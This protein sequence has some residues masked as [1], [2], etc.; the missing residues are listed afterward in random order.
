MKKVSMFFENAKPFSQLVGLFFLLLVGMI[1][2]GGVQA[3][4]PIEGEGAGQ[5]RMMLVVQAVSQL[6]MFL[7]PV[8]IFAG[9]F[10]PGI[11][12]YLKLKGKGSWRLALISMVM[13]VLLMPLN[14][15]LTW[16]NEGWQFGPIEESMR[17]MSEMEK[18]MLE[19]MVSLTT[20]G[21]LVLQL[22]IIALVPAVCEE[23]FFRGGVQ[24]IL[25]GWF[26]NR[27]VAVIVAALVF[28]LAHG[29][30]YGAVPRF[31]MGLLLGYLFAYS[32]SM[33]VNISAHF[34]N[35][36]AIVVMYYLYNRG[37]LS[38][39]PTEPLLMPWYVVVMCTVAVG[40]LFVVYF[41]KNSSKEQSNL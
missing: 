41:L 27:H 28:S 32:G 20:V 10:H 17:R 35:N 12:S 11:G 14:D 38:M 21:E 30:M 40:I 3:L 37:E 31:V 29:D 18:E 39:S 26:K 2:A 34:F 36:A 19:K 5:I 33:V 6:L 24:Q 23:L 4:I 15:V 7:I 13:V 16:W 8:L 25:S 1:M 22:V 9:L